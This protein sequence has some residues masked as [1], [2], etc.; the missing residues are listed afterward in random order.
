MKILYLLFASIH[1]CVSELL[2]SIPTHLLECYRGGGP[3]PGAPKRLDVFLNL[4]RRLELESRLDL[5]L[6]STS[7]L[8]SLRL[9]GIERAANVF[10]SEFLLPYR[11]SAFQ[12]HKYKMLMDLFLPSQDLIVADETLSLEEKCLLHKVLSSSVRPWERGDENIVCPLSAERRQHMAS[13]SASRLYSRCPIEDGVI[14]SPW[15]A[16]AP[17]TVVAAI[18]AS[19]ETQQVFVTDILQTNLFQE[20]IPTT[21]L[22]MA[23]REWDSKLERLE[24]NENGTDSDISNVWVATLAGDLAEVVVNLGVRVGAAPQRMTIGSINKWNDTLL[25][26]DY[27]LLMPNAT[28]ADWHMTDAEILAGIDG[29]IL[30]QHVPSWVAQRRTLRLSQIVEMYY[31]NEGVSFDP[32]VRACNRH[33]LFSEVVTREVLF[34]ETSRLAHVLALRQVTV[35]IP[36]EEMNRISD[37]AVS[38]FMD[39]VPS[40][41]KQYHVDC[42]ASRNIPTMDLIVATDSSWDGYRVQQFLS[43]IGGSLEINMQ[44]SSVALLHGNTGEWIVPRAHNLTALFTAIANYTDGWPNRLNLPNVVSSILQRTRNATLQDISEMR[45]AGPTTV[46]LVV[47]PTDRLSAEELETTRSLMRTL[48][49]SFFDVFFAYAAQDASDLKN[50]NNEYMDYS[51]LFLTVSST[52]V[53]DVAS[54]VDTHLL[55]NVIPSRIVGS[56]CAFNGTEYA[57]VPYEDFVLPSREQSYR[58]HPFYLWQQASIQVQFRNDGQGRIL[59]C[60]WR[61]AETSR[62]CRAVAEREAFSFNLTQPCP[63]PD[64]CPPA[65][66]I[67]TASSTQNLCAHVE[68]RFPHQVGYYLQHSGLRC[69]PLLGSAVRPAPIWKVLWLSILISRLRRD[70]QVTGIRVRWRLFKRIAFFERAHTRVSLVV[71]YVVTIASSCVHEHASNC[72]RVLELPVCEWRS[73]YD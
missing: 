69:L 21:I 13:T 18:A 52:S 17:G 36:L 73:C 6:F 67:V 35:Y 1:I 16:I 56:Q 3:A 68:C 5:R 42:V 58:I 19:L 28:S 55:K 48:R 59:V 71:V 39:Y 40:V 22:D 9:D 26:R 53:G 8:R 49:S 7:L 51:E 61:G 65:N 44:K 34:R 46:V 33:V 23:L 66:F 14:Q 54:A 4:V 32:N 25:P 64:F 45:S 41:L 10:E 29:L 43:W 11:A 50:I 37:A 63:S 24:L 38:A 72:S 62:S 2:S 47:T 12:F 70:G 15:G 30:A 20:E 31:S 27:Y 60:M 57:Q